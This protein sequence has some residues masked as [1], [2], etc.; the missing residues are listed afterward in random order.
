ML[1]LN[2]PF[3]KGWQAVVDGQQVKPHRAVGNLSYLE[4]NKGKHQISLSYHVP[5]LQISLIISLLALIVYLG[6]EIK[7]YFRHN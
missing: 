1:L 7:Y 4:L 3:D 2:I 5:G 6:V